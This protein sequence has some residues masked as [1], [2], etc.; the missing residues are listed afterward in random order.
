MKSEGWPGA[1]L[2]YRYE[3]CYTLDFLG[4]R[5]LIYAFLDFETNYCGIAKITFEEL[6]H[7]CGIKGD[8]K[9]FRS[10]ATYSVIL[11]CLQWF[12]DN[13]YITIINDKPLNEFYFKETIK[14]KISENF[15]PL[16]ETEYDEKTKRTKYIT[17]EPYITIDYD[18]LSTLMN[19]NTPSQPR[20]MAVYAYI[21]A[22]C[23]GRKNGQTAKEK[24][25]FM[26]ESYVTMAGNLASIRDSIQNYV[27]TLCD[28]GLVKRKMFFNTYDKNAPYVHTWNREGWEEELHYGTLICN[29]IYTSKYKKPSKLS[30][31]KE[32]E[33]RN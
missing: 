5:I 18:E 16:V 31:S 28:V 4:C 13:K 33:V 23:G 14:I 7:L 30:S 32:K 22:R 17:L 21:K 20:L 27:E 2:T 8:S 9:R 12:I 1:C 26:W 25:I 24:P 11:D 10:Y 3:S 6:F 29:E 19:L 15:L